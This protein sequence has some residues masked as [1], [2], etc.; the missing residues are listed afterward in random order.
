RQ[1]RPTYNSWCPSP[2]ERHVGLSDLKKRKMEEA[3]RV[4]DRI[5][6]SGA[7]EGDLDAAVPRRLLRSVGAVPGTIYGRR[8]KS[9]LLDK[10]AAYNQAARFQP[11]V[12]LLDLDQDAA[13]APQI[14]PRWLPTPAPQMCL[15]VAV[16]A[17][18]AWL[19]ADAERLA[20]FLHIPR[21]HIPGHPDA[22]DRPEQCTVSLARQ[23][24]SSAIRED[25]VPRPES[26][27]DVGPAYTARMIEFVQDETTGWWPEVA[28]QASESLARCLRRLRQLIQERR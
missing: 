16:R 25:I 4:P 10:L 19:L 18:D 28:A 21:Q 2:I 1:N 14:L 6:I 3:V 22:I 8:V 7:V 27:R 12:V 23:S 11:W 17:V 9:H 15:R 20:R 24:R 13:C 26:G 5:T